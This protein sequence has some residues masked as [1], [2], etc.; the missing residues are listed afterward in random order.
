MCVCARSR[1]RIQTLAYGIQWHHESGDCMSATVA[2]VPHI[3]KTIF[4]TNTIITIMHSHSGCL[5]CVHFVSIAKWRGRW[6]LAELL[7]CLTFHFHFISFHVLF[8]FNSNQRSFVF[9]TRYTPKRHYANSVA[10]T[11]CGKNTLHVGLCR[12]EYNPIE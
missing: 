8:P 9:C 10:R 1:L 4:R 7:Y 11:G 6:T 3:R 2:D 5:F 12:C